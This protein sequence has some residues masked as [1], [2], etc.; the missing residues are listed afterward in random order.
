MERAR[1]ARRAASK[2][3]MTHVWLRGMA[4]SLCRE[5]DDTVGA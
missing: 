3:M 2:G 1:C 4:A 5:R